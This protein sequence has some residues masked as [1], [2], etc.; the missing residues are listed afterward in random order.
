MLPVIVAG[1]VFHQRGLYERMACFLFFAMTFNKFLKHIFRIPLFPH[2]GKGY[3]FPS[4]HMHSTMMFYG[5]V[6]YRVKDRRIRALM[7]VILLGEA[8][9][10]MHFRFHDLADLLGAIGFALVEILC[11]HQLVSKFGEERGER[12]AAALAV[13]LSLFSIVTLSVLQAA[14]DYAWI[15]FYSLLGIVLATQLDEGTLETLGQR[16]LALLVSGVMVCLVFVIYRALNFQ[17]YSL[18]EMKFLF[19]PSIVIGSINFSSGRR[20][21]F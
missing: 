1:L 21:P 15:A 14:A 13:G 8:F 5:C 20:L 2:L 19:I 16:L 3:A 17:H 7:L 18:S 6:F 4:G 12:Y 10:L 9:S 11:Y